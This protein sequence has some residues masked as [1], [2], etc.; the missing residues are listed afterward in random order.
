MLVEFEVLLIFVPVAL[1]LNLTPGANMLFCLGQ[2]MK[3]GP[4]QVLRA[5]CSYSPVLYFWDWLRGL[6]LIADD[7]SSAN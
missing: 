4:K 7:L 6:R 3:S 2:G 1:A 5:R